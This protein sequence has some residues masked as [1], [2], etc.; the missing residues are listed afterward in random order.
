MSLEEQQIDAE[1]AAIL[2]RTPCDVQHGEIIET[3]M[4]PADQARRCELVVRRGDIISGQLA[5]AIHRERVEAQRDRDLSA[6]TAALNGI[7]NA[8]ESYPDLAKRL[9]AALGI[10]EGVN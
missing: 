8:I 9:R 7:I 10:A 2:A 4:T 5:E 6:A 3:H 1:L